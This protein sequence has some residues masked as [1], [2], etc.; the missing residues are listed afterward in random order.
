MTARNPILIVAVL[1]EVFPE[2]EG[3]LCLMHAN[4]VYTLFLVVDEV[5]RSHHERI[6]GKS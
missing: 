3:I 4:K 1:G 5:A 2:P 6:L